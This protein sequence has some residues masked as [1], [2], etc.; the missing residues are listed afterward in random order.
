MDIK[1]E[2]LAFETTDCDYSSQRGATLIEAT[3]FS[4]TAI[5]QTSHRKNDSNTQSNGMWFHAMHFQHATI[6]NQCPMQ[7][8]FGLF[9]GA[10]VDAFVIT[11]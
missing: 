8:L 6:M 3:R 5:T 4:S 10:S 1:K 9:N 2:A 7:K 11:K